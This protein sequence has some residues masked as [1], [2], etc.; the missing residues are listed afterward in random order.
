MATTVTIT[1][2][3]E[4]INTMLDAIG[5]SPVSSLSVVGLVDVAKAR[6]VLN[7]VS[8]QVQTKGWTFN[9][10]EHYPLN[11]NTDGEITMP[12]N[13][14]KVSVG[15]E[16]SSVSVA[17]RG[18]KLYDRTGHTY[19]FTANINGHVVFCLEWDELPQPARN[20]IMVRAARVFQARTLGSDTQHRFSSKDED[21]ARASMREFEGE[22][23]NLNMFTG[24]WSVANILN[25]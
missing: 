16:F 5:E 9:S 19:I 23:A 24:S 3:L 13:V 15:P 25:R 1:T 8:R 22:A 10:E 21:D 11:R 7:E 17:L 12:T 14:L 2:E 6:A 4:A 20:Y 18:T